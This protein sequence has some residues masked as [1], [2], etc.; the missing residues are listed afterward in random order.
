MEGKEFCLFTLSILID[1]E[2]NFHN[3]D[4]PWLQVLR[5]DCIPNICFGICC[6]NFISKAIAYIT[7]SQR[8]TRT[9]LLCH[10]I[11][12]D[13]GGPRHR[14]WI[15]RGPQ[16]KPDNE[17]LGAERGTHLVRGSGSEGPEAERLFALSQPMVSVG[18]LFFRKTKKN[19]SD[20]W[21]DGHYCNEN[22]KIWG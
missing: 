21:G 1:M 4:A 14:A 16:G 9:R 22:L 7:P 12:T 19:S 11:R 15:W 2:R 18:L 20:V 8:R 13:A 3:P 6:K 17:N 10:G 5:D